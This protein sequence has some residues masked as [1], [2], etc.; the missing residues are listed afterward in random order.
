MPAVSLYADQPEEAFP[1][2]TSS[3]W[4]SPVLHWVVAVSPGLSSDIW[5]GI[6]H[7]ACSEFT[8]YY[9]LHLRF[10]SR[11]GFSGPFVTSL[12]TS[13]YDYAEKSNYGGERVLSPGEYVSAR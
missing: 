11:T 5:P 4:T 13:P 3:V 6:D 10:G 8:H 2:R 7:G 9:G 1:L 12:S